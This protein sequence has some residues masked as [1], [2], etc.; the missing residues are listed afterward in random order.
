MRSQ[1]RSCTADKYHAFS[2]VDRV[3]LPADLEEG[4]YLIS[5]RWG[6]CTHNTVRGPM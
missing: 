1:S 2:I 5:W 4:D 6:A 3:T